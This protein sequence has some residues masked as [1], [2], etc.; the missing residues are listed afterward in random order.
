MAGHKSIVKNHPRHY[1]TMIHNMVSLP[2]DQN[3]SKT[4]LGKNLLFIGIITHF[5]L[6]FHITDYYH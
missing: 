1:Y 4:L 6:C 2:F 5:M 3:L